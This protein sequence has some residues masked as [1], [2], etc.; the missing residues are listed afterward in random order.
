VVIV[1]IVTDGQE[2]SSKEFKLAQV[3]D[4]IEHQ[5]ADYN[6]QFTFLGADANAFA[7]G[8]ALGIGA[9]ATAQYNPLNTQGAY[10]AASGAVSATRCAVAAGK[11]ADLGYTEDQR[12]DMT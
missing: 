9:H 6:W 12:D 8:A 1:V 3:K 11:D 10:L 2:N 4:M 5:R 7:D